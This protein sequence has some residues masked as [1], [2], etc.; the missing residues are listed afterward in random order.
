MEI[1]AMWNCFTPGCTLHKRK[2]A[3]APRQHKDA[4]EEGWKKGCNCH[5][6]EG[7]S[8]FPPNLP[9]VRKV[10]LDRRVAVLYFHVIDEDGAV[11]S[12]AGVEAVLLVP[13]AGRS[14][15]EARSGSVAKRLAADCGCAVGAA[16][17]AASGGWGRGQK[18]EGEDGER[19]VDNEGG[20]PNETDPGECL[21]SA[22]YQTGAVSRTKT[23]VCAARHVCSRLR[24][25]LPTWKSS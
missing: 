17:R 8:I 16:N 2:T 20:V 18:G 21:K 12:G 22:K 10:R 4:G 6:C 14:A 7:C 9:W 11:Q 24:H 13:Y 19:G 1:D 15:V 3:V 25:F 5:A 23:D